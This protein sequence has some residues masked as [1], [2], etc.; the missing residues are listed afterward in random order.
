MNHQE[1]VKLANGALELDVLREAGPRVVALTPGGSD[2]NLLAMVPE[3][4]TVTEWGPYHFRGGHRLWHAPEAAPRSYD[5]DDAG[6]TVSVD[7]LDMLV[8][9]PVEAHTGIRKSIR[10]VMD[11]KRAA[12]HVEHTLENSGVWPVEMGAW[13]ITQMCMGGT[14]ILP[15]R[16][17]GN[18]TGLLADR[19]VAFWPYADLKDARFH[20]ENDLFFV[21]GVSQP[22]AFKVG[23]YNPCGWVAY[24]FQPYLFVKRFTPVGG[25]YADFGCNAEIYVMDQFIEV[26]T[27]SPMKVLDPGGSMIHV[28]EWELLEVRANTPADAVIEAGLNA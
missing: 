20:C 4:V 5:P 13:A 12:V 3:A 6:V 1:T 17:P 28:E 24:F 26:E 15:V 18:A 9:G 8:R 25:Q 16:K 2:L 23:A 22:R 21:D 19:Q 10:F 11:A 27:Q 14:G 7:G